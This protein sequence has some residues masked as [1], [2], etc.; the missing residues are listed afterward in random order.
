[1]TQEE[2]KDL[3]AGG[4]GPLVEFKR[5]FTTEIARDIAAFANG[6]EASFLSEWMTT[7]LW[8]ESPRNLEE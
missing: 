3:V 6:G 5:E 7:L 2:L 8:S 1:M 4:E